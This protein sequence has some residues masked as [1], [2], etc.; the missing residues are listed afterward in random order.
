MHSPQRMQ[1]ARKYCSSSAPRGRSRHSWRA[2]ANPGVLR[3]SG[4][5][6]TPAA[7]PVRTFRRW[8]FTP[9]AFCPTPVLIPRIGYCETSCVL[10]SQVCPTGAIWEITEKEKGWS[11]KKLEPQSVL[12]ALVQ[13]V[14]TQMA[15][16]SPCDLCLCDSNHVS[17]CFPRAVELEEI[18]L[19]RCRMGLLDCGPAHVGRGADERTQESKR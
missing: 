14:Q 13:A 3:G 9:T 17:R 8:R 2:V 19:R 15:L 10:C 16:F 18:V 12:R 11:G 6:A 7:G 4:T 5:T 1:R